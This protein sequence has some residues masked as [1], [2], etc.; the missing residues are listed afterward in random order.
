MDRFLDIL[1]Y[2]GGAAAAALV[3]GLVAALWQP[4]R[5]WQSYIQHFAAGLVIAAVAVEMLPE[6]ERLHANGWLIVG[7]FAAGGVVMVGLKWLTHRIESRAE[8]TAEAFGLAAASGFDT[9]IDGLTIGGSFVAGQRMGFILAVALGVELLFLTLSLGSEFRSKGVGALRAGATAASLAL[10][11]LLGAFLGVLVL[12]G[13]PE[14]AL[15]AS[16][17]FGAAA[18]IYLVTEEL[19][20]EGHEAAETLAST[21]FL[22]LGF[23]GLLALRLLG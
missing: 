15:A 11:L 16:L 2:A 18:L 14:G 21:A 5:R 12:G 6:I 3:G 17:S 9:M 13:A 7:S 22:F 20:V 23:L 1:P 4:P 19:L 10:P 8:G